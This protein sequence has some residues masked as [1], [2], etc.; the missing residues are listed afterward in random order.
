MKELKYL[1]FFM[2]AVLGTFCLTSCLEEDEDEEEKEAK[3]SDFFDMTVTKC[4]RV[5]SV[6]IIDWTVKNKTKTDVTDLKFVGVNGYEFVDNNGNYYANSVSFRVG[7]NSWVSPEKMTVFAGESISGQFQVRNFDATNTA[8]KMNFDLLT[9]CATF[10]LY[11]S[12]V[13][14]T[15]LKITDNRVLSKGI[16]TNDNGLAWS[17][18]SSKR[19]A[20]KNVVVTIAVKNNTGKSISGF[21]LRAPYSTTDNSG[22]SY[23]NSSI[24]FAGGNSWLSV[25]EK[26]LEA[27]ETATFSLKS[28]NVSSS[29]KYYNAEI[30]VSADDYYFADSE[31][32]LLSIAIN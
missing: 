11:Q 22:N 3:F 8:T 15:N 27:G 23:Y 7:D 9:S 31:V 21:K 19:D 28:P 12:K 4:E 5:G 1:A 29:A 17:L 10:D 16:Q 14:A 26:N 32:R 25:A 6:L 30:S 2:V 13:S 24:K 20:D 18:V